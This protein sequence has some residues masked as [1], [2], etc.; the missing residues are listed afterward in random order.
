MQ[1]NW[2]LWYCLFWILFVQ[3]ANNRRLLRAIEAK[4]NAALRRLG[5]NPT[6]V[7][8]SLREA[9]QAAEAEV[10]WLAW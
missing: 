6:Q 3:T 7:E 9:D 5:D 2:W 10:R 1:D 8:A 4:L